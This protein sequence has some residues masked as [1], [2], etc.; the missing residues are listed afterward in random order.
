MGV[1]F[2]KVMNSFD[3]PFTKIAYGELQSTKGKISTALKGGYVINTAANNAFIAVND[4]IKQGIDVYRIN[5]RTNNDVTTGSF[6]VAPGA[7]ALVE[8]YVSDYGLEVTR[9]TKRP[10]GMTKV[11]PSRIALWDTYGGSMSSGW[12]RW[13]MEQYH[14]PFNVIYAKEI[15]STDLHKKY[16]VIV[17][18]TGAIPAIR[19]GTENRGGGQQP[20]PEDIPAEFRERLGRISAD[21]SIPQ[22]RKFMQAGGT[23]VTIGS[24]TNLAYH[25]KLPVRNALVEMNNGQERP[26]PGEKFYIPGSIMNVTVD[27]TDDATLGMTSKPDVYYDASPVFKIAPGAIANGAVKPLAWFATDKPLRSGWAWGQAYLQDGVAAFKAPVGL[28]KLVAFGPEITFRGQTHGTFKLL[29]NQL[30]RYS[31]K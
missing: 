30:F 23:I 19:T 16:D 3:G 8:K 31:N 21:T 13:I 9:I 12:V 17:F 25:L 11:L 6:Y 5:S 14:F 7:K 24:S 20:K 26:L 1:K 15:D 22:L 10:A 18:V 29:F 4:L 27:T 28:G 2:D